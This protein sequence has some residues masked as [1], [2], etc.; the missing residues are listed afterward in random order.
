M[1]DKGL[2]DRMQRPVFGDT[3]D[4]RYLRAVFHHSQRQAGI[5]PAAVH[6]NGTG[7]ALAVIAPFLCPGQAE[8]NPERVEQSGPRGDSQLVRCAIGVKRD[9]HFSG[10]RQVFSSFSNCWC[11]GHRI[12]PPT[13]VC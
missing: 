3:F 7:A 10:R 13:W 12:V 4:C 1:V 6:Q 11:S 9:R 8:M 5:D 2:L